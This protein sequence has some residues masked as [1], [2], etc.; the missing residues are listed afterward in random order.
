MTTERAIPGIGERLWTW[1][2]RP[3]RHK[4]RSVAARVS[5]WTSAA[6]LAVFKPARRSALLDSAACRQAVFDS[7]D[8]QAFLVSN[9]PGETLIVSA[10]DKAIGRSV[11]VN[12]TPYDFDKVESVVA[13]LG[14]RSRRELL[15]DVGANIG[16]IC[17]PAVKRRVFDKAIAIEPEPRNFAL[18]TA[19]VAINGLADRIVTHNVAMGSA[20]HASLLFELSEDNF[21]DHRVRSEGRPSLG[22]EPQRPTITVPSA[23][24]DTL[25]GAVDPASTVIWVDT[26]GFEGFVLAGATRALAT[27]T[28]MCLEFWPYGMVRSGGFPLL[29]TALI[30]SGYTTFYDLKEQAGPV[31]LNDESLVRLYRRLGES[32]PFTDLLVL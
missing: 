19:N 31:E 12:R 23:R 27:R 8:P 11:F 15:I 4:V 5:P 30:E 9:G 25:V 20:D 6:M 26:Q 32:G 24:F 14:A 1:V 16:S 29:K 17:I 28:P 21:G 3:T 22:D 13:L 10:A 18:L 7:A 2:K